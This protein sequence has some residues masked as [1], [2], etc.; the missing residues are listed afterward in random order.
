MKKT[1]ALHLS[2][3]SI[4]STNK[5]IKHYHV[6]SILLCLLIGCATT[7]HMA[8]DHKTDYVDISRESIALLS[9]HVA[10]KYMPKH[11]L[12][13]DWVVVVEQGKENNKEYAIEVGKE[14]EKKE[15]NEFL[16]SFQL[17]PGKYQFRPFRAEPEYTLSGGYFHLPIFSPFELEGNKVIYLGNISAY[18]KKITSNDELPAGPST[19]VFQQAYFGASTGTFVINISDQYDRDIDLFRKKFPSLSEIDI[20]KR[21]L[22]PWEKPKKR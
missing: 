1:I 2:Y 14:Y 17:P 21:I 11:Q 10:N 13:L 16:I 9:V 15:Y 6:L 20:Q 19:P 8:L 18:V 4:E 3:N 5:R 7:K 22:P 12:K